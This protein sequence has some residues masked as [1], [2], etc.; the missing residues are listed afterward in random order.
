M[1]DVGVG[2]GSAGLHRRCSRP[3]PERPVSA[4]TSRPPAAAQTMPAR[5]LQISE[6]GKRPAGTPRCST[7]P[8]DISNT[9]ATADALKAF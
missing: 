1:D 7:T 4:V 8:M 6:G 3:L 9:R 5:R 2:P